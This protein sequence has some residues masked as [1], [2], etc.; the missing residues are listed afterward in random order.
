M[1]ENTE[2]GNSCWGKWGPHVKRMT[3]Q[4]F[5]HLTGMLFSTYS[6]QTYWKIRFSLKNCLP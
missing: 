1:S 2:E 4:T 3:V 5:A 6:E